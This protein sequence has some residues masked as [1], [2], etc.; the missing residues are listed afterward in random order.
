MKRKT[1]TRIG[2]WLVSASMLV[3]MV[4]TYVLAAQLPQAEPRADEGLVLHY[5][6]ESLK[7]G[8]IVND[9]SGNGKSGEVMPRGSGVET[10]EVE[11]FGETQTAIVLQGGQ[12]GTGHNYVEMPAGVLNGLD[13]VTISCWVYVNQSSGYA[14]IWDI[15]HNT[16]S[17]MYLLDS[18]YNTG[19]TGY[20]AALTNSGWGNERWALKRAP[21]WTPAF[22]S[23]PP[24]PLT[25]RPTP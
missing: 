8:T 19:H 17:Y 12:P 2:T 18:G 25:G 13:S 4:P 21:L 15:G 23:S 7:T 6:F 22:G 3:G 9:V 5:D 11:I 10:K 14:R 1:W 16:T 20:T 24:S